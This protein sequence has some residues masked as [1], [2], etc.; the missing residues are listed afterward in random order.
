MNEK[1]EI[2][3]PIYPCNEK[4]RLQLRALRD[5]PEG[6]WNNSRIAR[7]IG[8]S[9]AAVSEYLNEKGN[10]WKNVVELEKNVAAFLRNAELQLDSGVE[11]VSCD[12]AEQI[13][14][15]VEEIRT[16]KRAGVIIG[17]P[18]IGKSRGIDLLTTRNPLA[19]AFRVC[20]WQ[21]S[22]S[23]FA[24]CLFRAAEV[25][26]TKR[27]M[28]GM[29]LLAEKLKGSARPFLV[30]DAH[31]LTRAALQLGYDFR[32]ATGVP[33]VLLGDERLI[34]KLKDDPQRLRRTG[35]VFRLKL[36]EPLPLIKHHIA[37]LCPDVDGEEREL[38]ALCRKVV[39]NPGHFGCLQME[40][41]LAARFKRARADWSW[42]ECVRRAHKKLIRDY[43]LN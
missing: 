11:T 26:H 12:I 8:F 42:C 7:E 10:R 9:A 14:D 20:A 21:K 5:L 41:S 27:G 2:Q 39:E 37:E 19:V 16:A 32:D 13:A 3:R 34:P 31:K 36:H 30:D 35:L 4:L 43:E 25:G 28:G 38:I 15:A 1:D 6:E 40:L 29:N 23:D 18:G 24:E 33:L 22:Q 17:A